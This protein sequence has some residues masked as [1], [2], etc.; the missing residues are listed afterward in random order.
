MSA[1]LPA[2][3]DVIIVEKIRPEPN[4]NKGTCCAN[5]GM[6]PGTAAATLKSPTIEAPL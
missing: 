5:M 4:G 2:F 1:F 6:A 3:N